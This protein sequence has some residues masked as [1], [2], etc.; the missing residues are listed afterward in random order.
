MITSK[1][2]PPEKKLR[3]GAILNFMIKDQESIGGRIINIGPNGFWIELSG[4][5]RMRF[6]NDNIGKE[7]EYAGERF[8]WDIIIKGRRI[9]F[10]WIPKGPKITPKTTDKA[11]DLMDEAVAAGCETAEEFQEFYS[12]LDREGGSNE[13][14]RKKL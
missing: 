8:K 5:K 12:K 3:I 7:I 13:L 4:N 11:I 2:E 14:G 1:D 9:Y 6:T 10:K